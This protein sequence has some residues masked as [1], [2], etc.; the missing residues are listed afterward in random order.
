MFGS[1]LELSCDT[2]PKDGQFL[3]KGKRGKAEGKVL[4]KASK[5]G[6]SI[7]KQDGDVDIVNELIKHMESK[8]KI[9]TKDDF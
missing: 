3:C 2:E 5:D 4:M 6:F 1:N 9:R 7:M 8:G